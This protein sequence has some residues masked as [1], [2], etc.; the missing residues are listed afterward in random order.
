MGEKINDKTEGMSQQKKQVSSGAVR[1]REKRKIIKQRGVSTRETGEFW[2]CQ[3]SGE[4]I[5]DKTE[6]VSQQEK[7]LSSGAVRDR[8]KR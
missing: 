4:K 3:R 2:G 1:D 5:N 7:Q 8:E 6:G